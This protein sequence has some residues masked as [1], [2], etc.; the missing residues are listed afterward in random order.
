MNVLVTGAA[1]W[2]AAAILQQLSAAG[3][4][5]VLFDLPGVIAGRGWPVPPGDTIAGDVA[6]FRD[7]F[8]AARG[9]DAVVHLAVAVEEGAYQDP[10]VPF[11]ADVQGTFD[12]FEAARRHRVG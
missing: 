3:H 4:E 8:D 9:V 5:L 10:D 1:G 2:T 12:V 11:A 7:V 6:S